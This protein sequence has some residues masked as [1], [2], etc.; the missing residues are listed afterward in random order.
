MKYSE[1]NPFYKIIHNNAPAITYYEN[2]NFLIIQDQNPYKPKSFNERSNLHLLLIPK[3]NYINYIDFFKN[4]VKEETTDFF[5]ALYEIIKEYKLDSYLDKYKD[6]S[7][8]YSNHNN[9]VFLDVRN[10]HSHQ[11]IYHFHTHI[12]IPDVHK[13]KNFEDLSIKNN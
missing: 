13:D 11:T 8:L 1:F 5:K 4:A 7:C 6:Y 9:G 2:N 10:G 12:H 3:G